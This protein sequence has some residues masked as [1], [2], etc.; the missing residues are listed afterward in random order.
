[1]RHAGVREAQAA[2]LA[3]R[4]ELVAA[5]GRR[6][7]AVRPGV[8]QPPRRLELDDLAFDL[9]VGALPADLVAAA[10]PEL[11]VDQTQ[12]VRQALGD[13]QRGPDLLD[14]LL[15]PA[16]EDDVVAP[17]VAD[18]QLAEVVVDEGAEGP[19]RHCSRSKWSMRAESLPAHWR[20]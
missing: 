11:E 17:V 12:P 9:V 18:D 7:A 14:R 3:V 13:R 6:V 5:D 2:T 20:R 19:R 15:D 16:L 8:R 4:L 1:S 10:D